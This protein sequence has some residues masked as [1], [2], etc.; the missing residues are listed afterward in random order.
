MRAPKL[1]ILFITTAMLMLSAS[2]AQAANAEEPYTLLKQVGEQLFVDIGNI[3]AEEQQKKA[4]LRTLV[5]AQLIPHIDTKFVSFKLLGKHVREI[6]KQQ[7]LTFIGAIESYLTNTYANALMSYT[8]QEVH[9]IKPNAAPT[10]GYATVKTEIVEAGKPTIDIV[11]KL[12][13]DKAGSWRVYDLVAEG[14]S[15]LDAKQKEIIA[16]ITEVGI[17]QVNQELLAKG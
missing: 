14:I 16:R 9:F 12:R 11:F 6:N 3:D 13:Q 8:G 1:F 7:A 15:L 10:N 17:D 2:K 5:K 4:Q